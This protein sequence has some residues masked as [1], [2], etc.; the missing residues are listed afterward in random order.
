MIENLNNNQLKKLILESNQDLDFISIC[1]KNTLNILSFKNIVDSYE[2]LSEDD[3]IKINNHPND[4]EFYTLFKL[5]FNKYATLSEMLL[6][7]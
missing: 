5:S 2:P 1:L 6:G 7:H 4:K 3:I